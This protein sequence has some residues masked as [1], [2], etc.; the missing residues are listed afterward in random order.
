MATELA[1]SKMRL[2]PFLILFRCV[3]SRPSPV[4]DPAPVPTIGDFRYAGNGCPQGSAST[5]L[6]T[7]NITTG[8]YQLTTELD[9]YTPVVRAGLSGTATVGNNCQFKLNIAVPSGW[10]LRVNNE[11]TKIHG[12]L[13]LLDSNTTATWKA[14]YY[15]DNLSPSVRHR[16]LVLE[17]SIYIK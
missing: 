10:H 12:R 6:A 5:S 1:L 4:I 14:T 13:L 8:V 2:I 3:T 7:V 11:G 15:F 16:K 17:T 9:A